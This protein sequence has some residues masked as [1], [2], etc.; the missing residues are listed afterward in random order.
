MKKWDQIEA[1]LDRD[2]E[3]AA[4]IAELE[5][6]EQIARRLI[7]YRIEHGITQTELA[8]R[9]GMSQPAI[10]RLESAQHEPK[11]STLRKVA[12]ALGG[13]LVINLQVEDERH[14]LETI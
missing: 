6:W 5:P 11:L 7:R 13:E 14:E 1:E 4:A 10:A 2:T 12:H 9:C 3:H 8:R